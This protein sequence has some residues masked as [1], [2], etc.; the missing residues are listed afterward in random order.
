MAMLLKKHIEHLIQASA[1]ADEEDRELAID[2]GIDI[3]QGNLIHDESSVEWAL[4]DR[5]K[6][7]EI[8][9]YLSELDYG[10]KLLC[11]LEEEMIIV[12]YIVSIH[13]YPSMMI[14]R[15]R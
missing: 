10:S 12:I 2:Y 6:V 15:K 1:A 3:S 4:A 5:P 9:T 14:P 11:T 8:E 7:R 13:I